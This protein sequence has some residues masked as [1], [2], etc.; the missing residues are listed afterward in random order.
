M[1]SSRGT[2][3]CCG[4]LELEGLDE[5]LRVGEAQVRE[6]A[7][8]FLMAARR[9]GEVHRHI[10]GARGGEGFIAEVSMDET[11]EPQKPA[12][13]L[14]ILAALA[15]QGVPAQTIAPKFSGRFNK[16]VDYVGDVATFQREFAADV[17]VIAHAV[18]AY[19][20]PA[21]LKLSVHSGSDKFSLYPAIHRVMERT[22]CGVH[23]K[24]AGTTW[25]EEIIGLAESG[26]DALALVNELYQEA[27]GDI[28][29][30]CAPYADVI[31]VDRP[32]LPSTEEAASWSGDR[33]ARAVRHVPSEADFNPS[34]RQLLHVAFKVAARAG[35]RY[36][37]LLEANA[38]IVGEQVTRNLLD[39]HMR[40]LFLG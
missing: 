12:A 23:L 35:T 19:D 21:N 20:L 33:W 4:E 37:D 14:V 10:A 17:A 18:Q 1:R 29:A 36:T 31:D 24:T 5:P 39:R 3:N 30:F 22:G 32:R 15:D 13:L 7:S 25:L 34:L 26:G 38:G 16:G 40:P 8:G 2:V 28:D 11:P 6:V 27:L 9:A